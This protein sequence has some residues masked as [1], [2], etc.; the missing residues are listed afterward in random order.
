MNLS[1]IS[2]LVITT[3][4][5]VTVSIFA[6]MGFPFSWVFSLIVFGQVFLIFSVFKILKDNYTTTKTFEDFYEDF[7]IGCEE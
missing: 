2:Y 4:T 3:F 6:T 1:A 7:P 5:L